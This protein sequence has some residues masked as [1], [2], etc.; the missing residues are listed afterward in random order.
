MSYTGL[1]LSEAS[2]QS[3]LEKFQTLPVPIAHHM[4]VMMDAKPENLS[5]KASFFRPEDIGRA[6]RLQVVGIARSTEIETVVVAVMQDDGIL[7]SEGVV[8]LKK[9]HTPHITVATDG[10]TKPAKSKDLLSAGYEPISD[11]PVLDA[12]LEII[13]G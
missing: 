11:G 10:L 12:T 1:V 6:F 8:D 13:Q 3:L 4:T 9:N 7:V 5:R 2:R